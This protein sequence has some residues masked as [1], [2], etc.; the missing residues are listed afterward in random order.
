MTLTERFRAIFQ[1]PFAAVRTAGVREGQTV[2]DIGAGLG[3]FTIATAETVGET[4]LVYAIEPDNARSE[5]IRRRVAEGKVQNV[6]VLTTGAEQLGDVQSDSV[7][8]A[9]SAF[10][11]H[12]FNDRQVA[13]AEVRRILKVG[14]SFYMWD[15]MP[16]LLIRHGTQPEELNSLSAGFSNLELL[17]KKG[18]TRARFTK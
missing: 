9:F 13:L 15:R 14:G 3:Y 7:D 17:S 11:M 4:G 8:L 12:H 18:T 2:A 10:S 16:G 1:D 5:K 6:R